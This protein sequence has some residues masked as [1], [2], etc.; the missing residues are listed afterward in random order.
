M[1]SPGMEGGKADRYDV[2]AFATDGTK[3]VFA[4]H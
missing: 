3:H 2:I 4:K 1:G